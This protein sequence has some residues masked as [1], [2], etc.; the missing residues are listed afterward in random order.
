MG[1][2]YLIPTPIGENDVDHVIPQYNYGIIGK[3]RCFVIE[4]IRT[5]R[6]FLRKI[7]QLFPI[8]DCSFFELNEH[9]VNNFD[10]SKVLQL[11]KDGND[12]GL[13]SE[14]GL[15]CIADPGYT[16]VLAAQQ[17][18]IHVVP[19]VGPSSLMMALMAS[20]LCGQNFVFH[21]YLPADKIS[22]AEKIKNIELPAIKYNQTQIFIEAPYRNM[23]LFEAL[24][25]Y[26]HP[27]TYLCVA[28][29]IS[30]PDQFIKTM[31]IESWKRAKTINIHKKPTVFLLG[32]N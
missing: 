15:P 5:A 23:Q 16:L 11:L 20:G 18:H 7:D 17:Q 13:M 6:R 21:G 24:L 28:C 10:Y 4:E 1:T 22:L 12:V 27:Q 3:L 26:C 19:L 14:A 25:K 8:D 2:L 29:Q 32:I 30:Q 31:T 9:V